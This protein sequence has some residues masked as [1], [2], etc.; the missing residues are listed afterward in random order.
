MT[1][2]AA[3]PQLDGRLMTC[4]GGFE[5]WLQYIDGFTLRH[6]CAFELLDDDRGR[7]CLEAYHRKLVEAAVANGFGVI[8]EGRVAFI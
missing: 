7:A 2:A 4:G 1:D 5:T 6:F 3:L 8:N